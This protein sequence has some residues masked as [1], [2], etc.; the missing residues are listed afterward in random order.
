MLCYRNMILGSIT[1]RMFLRI[2]SGV[3]VHTMFNSYFQFSS[4]ERCVNYFLSFFYWVLSCSDKCRLSFHAS[5]QPR[6]WAVDGVG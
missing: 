4:T 5:T 3:E 2:L 6:V 1:L